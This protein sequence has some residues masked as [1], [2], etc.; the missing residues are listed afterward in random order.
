MLDAIELTDLGLAMTALLNSGKIRNLESASGFE[1][2]D[3]DIL[4]KGE[5]DFLVKD[6]GV[7]HTR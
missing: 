2:R 7:V 3:D 4:G 5:F 1:V 6:A